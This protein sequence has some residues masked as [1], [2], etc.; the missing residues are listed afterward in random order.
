M[1]KRDRERK[2]KKRKNEWW[3]LEK[4]TEYKKGKRLNK[5]V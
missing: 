2:R 3:K 4:E 5:V 1:R